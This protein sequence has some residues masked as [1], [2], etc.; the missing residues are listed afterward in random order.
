MIV[1]DYGSEGLKELLKRNGCKM[2]VSQEKKYRYKP[3]VEKVFRSIQEKLPYILSGT[4]RGNGKFMSY[5]T[6]IE[7]EVRRG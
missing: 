5:E 7:S 3:D 1:L 6:F 4:T 2:V